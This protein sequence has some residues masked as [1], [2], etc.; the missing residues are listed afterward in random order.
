MGGLVTF[1]SPQDLPEGASPR[2]YDVDYIVGS[3]F[4]RPGLQNVYVYANTLSISQLIVYNS[5]GTFNYTGTAPSINEEFTLSGFTSPALFLNGL[6]ISVLSVDSEAGVFTADVDSGNAT[7]LS[8]SGIAVSSVGNFVGPNAPTVAADVNTGGNAWTN[9]NGVLGDSTYSSVQSESGG[10]V[11]QVPEGA[12]SIPAPTGYALWTNPSNL[13]SDSLYT[14]ISISA[15]QASAEVLGFNGTIAIPTDATIVGMSVSLQAYCSVYGVGSLNVQLA[16][17]A[18]EK[19]IGTAINVPLPTSPKEYTLGSSSYTWGATLTPSTVNGSALGVTVSAKV[20]SGTAT[21]HAN[22]LSVTVYYSLAGSTQALRTTGYA[23]AVPSTSI[24]SGIGA[25]FKAYSSANT[26]VTLQLVKDGVPVGST[27]TQTL[28]TAPTVYE[29]G[30]DDDLWGTVL[31]ASDVNNIDFGVQITASGNGES[32]IN[33]LDVLTYITPAA[34]NFNYI[35]SYIQDSQ[36]TYTLALDASGILWVENVTESQDVLTLLYSGILPG[37]YAKSATADNNEYVCFSDLKAGTDR[38]RIIR[39]NPA[40]GAL[41][42]GSLSGCGPAAPPS[43]T[44]ATSS[45]TGTLTITAYSITDNVVTFTIEET[46]AAPVVG[47]LYTVT[48]TGI[49]G[50]DAQPLDGFPYTVLGTPTPTT[51]SFAIAFTADNASGSIS[52][53]AAPSNFYPIN[54]IVQDWT[55]PG[56]NAGQTSGALNLQPS[57]PGSPY[58]D[59]AAA[60]FNGQV[61]V[62]G[63]PTGTASTTVTFYYGAVGQ[64]E[65]HGINGTGSVQNTPGVSLLVQITDSP[66]NV[67]DGTWAITGHGIGTPPHESGQIPYFQIVFSS[68]NAQIYGGPG[69]SGPTGL[70]GNDGSFQITAAV[71][72]AATPIPNLGVG[73]N[74]VIAEAS[75]SGWNGTWKVEAALNSASFTIN[76]SQI[77]N[78]VATITYTIVNGT[79]ADGDVVL[80]SNMNNPS[81]LLDTSG[82]IDN[83]TSTSFTMAG[84]P[85]TIDQTSSFTELEGQGISYGTIFVFEPGTNGT[86]S[87]SAIFGDYTTGHAQVEVIGGNIIPIGAGTRQAVCFFISETG[88][89]SPASPFI[90]FTVPDEAN[91]LTIT[92]LPIGPP[93]TVARGIAFTEA[94]QNGVAGANF[95]VIENPVVITINGVETTYSSTIVQDNVTT[96]N[97]TPIKLTFTDS[98]LLDSTEIDIQ[99]QDQFNLIE[100]G[101]SAWCVPYSQRMFYGLQ[102][103]KVTNF[104]NLSF[105]GGYLPPSTGANT[106]PLGFPLGA[107]G[108]PGT[109]WSIL[110]SA[111]SSVVVS[112]VTGNALYIKNGTGSTVSLCGLMQQT[113]YQDQYQV[114]IL[115][116]NTLYSVRVA[117]S[118][119][120]GVQVGTLTIDL[121]DTATGVTYGKF[122]VPLSQMS[123]TVQVFSGTLLT[124]IFTSAVPSTLQL[125]LY[126]S[127]MGANSD[128]LID[129][130]EVFPTSAPYL[131]AQVYGSYINDLEAIDASD[132]GGIIDTTSENTQFCYGGF[133]MHNQLFLLKESSMYSTEDNPNS[134]P[135]GWSLKEVS[136]KVGACGIHAYDVGEEWATTACRAGI[137]G[138]AGGQPIPL[139]LEIVNLWGC[140]NWAAA[141][142]IVLR[143]DINDRKL[144]CWVPLP[145]GPATATY[146]WLP[147][148]PYNPTPSTPNVCLM[149]NYQGLATAM[150]LFNGPGVH[151]TMFGTLAAVDMKRK[152]SIWQV[153][154]PYADFI[155][156]QDS[157]DNPLFVC[158]GIASS[159]IYQFEE[160]QYSDDGVAIH[161][162]YCT[163]GFV[164]A[165]KAATQP[166]FGLH[167]KRYTVLQVT[168]SGAGIMSTALLPNIIN[169]KYPYNVP[170]GISLSDPAMDD[171]FRPVNVKGN[172]MFLE[173][174]TNAVDSYFHLDKVLLTGKADAWSSLNPLG[175]GN[176]GI[177]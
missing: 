114:D 10:N 7:Y 83:V 72:Q 175:G 71:L 141:N 70:P 68:A 137:Y 168:A 50:D 167:T 155:Y 64:P 19:N 102:L 170:V 121:T 90:E 15:G 124:Q 95:Y 42:L 128:C 79:L 99:G 55:L 152:W 93:G 25:S 2:N 75:P 161:A 32:Y 174:S 62:W 59:G 88:Y 47:S 17:P 89:W 158:N 56:F 29:L 130:A 127:G 84:F 24:I 150:E 131:G 65:N 20:T 69:G 103:N 140:I 31:K 94:G 27:R 49:T 133:V 40:T 45:A 92:N 169:P 82:G 48:G 67:F 142:T 87:E 145:T 30:A 78:G 36:Q 76:S 104:N 162:D 37:S 1:A 115:E 4:Q 101:S 165:T 11:T 113:A 9:P 147:N 107:L 5:I 21:L 172:R 60:L 22:S 111:N 123:T 35:K 164:N 146:L 171:Y 117:A 156:R 63:T 160:S 8:L 3:V 177:A 153:P 33:D 134:E 46:T 57:S 43:I 116:I 6:V 73:D 41:Q 112:P 132:N 14:T 38:P 81:G 18:T 149:L 176:A 34:V 110:D 91:F 129:R 96:G 119:P 66:N 53:Q 23:F 122:S 28:T 12:A 85:G 80:L 139:T 163:Y 97:V 173:F 109:G 98:V 52:G 159:K 26:S 108:S 105:D 154:S 58:Y 44:T 13:I 51:T 54:L 106:Q 61:I 135:G 16:N 100:L 120:S 144:Y 126:V 74:I 166:I 151:T 157:V 125:R 39:T 118:N 143:N 136:N 148:A 138:F 77:Q 86:V